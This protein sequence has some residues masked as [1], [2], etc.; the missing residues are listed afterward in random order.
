MT[1]AGGSGNIIIRRNGGGFQIDQREPLEFWAKITGSGTADND[2]PAYAWK[3]VADADEDFQDLDNGLS[4][5]VDSQPAF[6]AN[7][8]PDIQ[9]GTIVW[10]TRGLG[11]YWNFLFC[12]PGT[13]EGYPYGYRKQ[14]K[15]CIDVPLKDCVNGQMVPITFSIQSDFP[16][17]SSH[18]KCGTKTTDPQP[19]CPPG[20]VD[21]HKCTNKDCDKGVYTARPF[22]I[23]N[24]SCKDCQNTWNSAFDMAWDA[25]NCRWHWNN[26]GGLNDSCGTLQAN[27]FYQNG[28]Y[29]ILFTNGTNAIYYQLDG[30]A[31]NAGGPN[32]LTRVGPA[33]PG[34][35][36]GWPDTMTVR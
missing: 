28:F 9:N 22:G 5:K 30:M 26:I 10:L 34:W 4:G 19:P 24:G 20:W 15:Y 23:T 7:D 25:P 11:D 2:R 3:Q 8:T 18:E 1:A 31:W 32:T 13:I 16:I 29:Y 27:L 6:E 17:W 14:G 36:N 12:C 33:D 35:C 21:T